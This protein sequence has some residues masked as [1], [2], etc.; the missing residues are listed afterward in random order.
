MACREE[1]S[2]NAWLKLIDPFML[3]KV[4]LR[5]VVWIYISFDNNLGIK[6]SFTKYLKES[7]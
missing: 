1:Y 2:V 4:T 6:N 3:K 7:C 5:I